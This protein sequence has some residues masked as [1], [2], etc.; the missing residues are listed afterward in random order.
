[1]TDALWLGARLL[2]LLAIANNAPLA[3]KLVLGRR[4]AAAIDGGRQW[5]DG[6]PVLGPSKT[7]RG[8]LAAIVLTALA[9]PWLGFPVQAG[10]ALGGLAM[11]GDALASFAKRRLGIP[12]SGRA[13]GLD[14]VPES[15]LPLLVLQP[16]LDLPWTVVVG[17]VL[18]FLL[19]E[20]PGARLAHRIGWRDTPH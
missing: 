1:M 12:S 6:R 9:A 7:W 11:V 19:L 13:F 18:A 14:Q 3:A 2:L 20:T 15:L 5:R 4:W 16:A 8:L 10:A 17:V